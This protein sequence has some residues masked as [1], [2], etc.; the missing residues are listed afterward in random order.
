MSLG[1]PLI[2]G[3]ALSDDGQRVIVT[4]SDVAYELIGGKLKGSVSRKGKSLG[5]VDVDQTGQ[6][7]AIS[8][9][10]YVLLL[11]DRKAAG[12]FAMPAGAILT[13][14]T[15]SQRVLAWLDR[16]LTIA[17]FSGK[18]IARIEFAKRISRACLLDNGKVIVGAGHLITLDTAAPTAETTPQKAAKRVDAPSGD[19]TRAGHLS[20]RQGIEQGIPVR[21]IEGSKLQKDQGKAAYR[22]HDGKP[23]TIE[24]LALEHYSDR[25]CRGVWSENE[26]WWAIMALLF[27][28]VV[29]ARLPGVYTPQF[30]DFPSKMQDMPTDFFTPEFYPRRKKLI[31]RRI[32]ELTGSRFFG[33]RKPN[34]EAALTAA[35]RRHRGTPCRPIDWGRAPA[36][37][38]LITAPKNLAD[39][40]LMKI[41]R[42]LLENFAQNRSGLPD[43]FLV[44]ERSPLFAEV[45]SERERVAENQVRWLRFLKDEM[46]IS[47]EVC[48]V[49][50]G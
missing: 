20:T 1:P 36:L 26:Y 24:Q 14:G 4:T 33:L 30:G 38:E 9:D 31:D 13:V 5:A 41:M 16:N 40:Q 6:L 3:L 23:I 39:D 43:L 27:W 48:R 34:I 19:A 17:T 29:F 12:R 35:Y 46:G 25:N 7:W 2:R 47:V 49:T 10:G 15:A 32:S 21:W 8:T 28:D 50:N 45:K 37:N 22:S 11:Q 18:T 44:C 42:R